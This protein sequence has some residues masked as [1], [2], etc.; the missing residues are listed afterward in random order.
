MYAF[1]TEKIQ[2]WEILRSNSIQHSD[3]YILYYF[4]TF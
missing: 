2:Y 4:I 1:E 3:I